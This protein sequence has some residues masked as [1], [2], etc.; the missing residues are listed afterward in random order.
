MPNNLCDKDYADQ[1]GE[2][3]ECLV[4][5]NASIPSCT[6]VTSEKVFK[7]AEKGRYYKAPA[8]FI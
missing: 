2:D 1:G 4:Q 3:V 5:N 8:S 6:S 7:F